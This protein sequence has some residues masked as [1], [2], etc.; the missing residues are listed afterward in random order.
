MLTADV[1]GE[2]NELRDGKLTTLDTAGH[3]PF[4]LILDS[5]DHNVRKILR[6]CESNPGVFKSIGHD[7]SAILKVELGLE[8]VNVIGR[9]VG[10]GEVI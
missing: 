10:M 6:C 1:F 2:P 9:F 3:W 5:L 8:G 7:S 4:A